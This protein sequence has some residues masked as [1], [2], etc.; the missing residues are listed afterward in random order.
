MRILRHWKMIIGLMAIFGAGVG[1][2]GVGTLVVL[3][4]VFTTPE[5]VQRWVDA[6]VR[7]LESKLKL[8]PEQKLRIRPIIEKAGGRFRDIGAEA[9]GKI[10]ATAGQT[11]DE[12]AQELTPA[13]QIEFKKMR[14]QVIARLRELAQREIN[15]KAH[16]NRSPGPQRPDL[17]TPATTP[18]PDPAVPAKVDGK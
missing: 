17:E 12:V 8:T 6:R 3:R 16:G 2:G 1:T 9:F 7:E 4:R 18:S 15:V 14:Q 11:H 5:P 13:Q 10:M